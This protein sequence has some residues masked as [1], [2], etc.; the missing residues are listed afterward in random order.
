MSAPPISLIEHGA[1]DLKCGK[2]AVFSLQWLVPSK[3]MNGSLPGPFK[4]F[5][6]LCRN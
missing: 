4:T 6:K 2:S 5:S 3:Y 1:Q